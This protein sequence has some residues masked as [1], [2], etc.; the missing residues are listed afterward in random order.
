MTFRIVAALLAA[1]GVV[2]CAGRA[3][4]RTPAR[5]TLVVGQFGEFRALNPLYLMGYYQLEIDALMYTRLVWLDG[6]GKL[7]PQLATA[8]PSRENGGISRDGLTITYHLRHDAHWSDGVPLTSRDVA[9]THQ[10]QM[11]PKNVAPEE[12][13]DSEIR[14][15]E[16]P[17][18][19]TVRVHLKRPW[20]PFISE[21]TRGILPAHILGTDAS[22]FNAAF[23]AHPVG[24]GPYRFVEWLRGDHVTFEADP[25][26][27][28]RKPRI[29]RIQF[30]IIPDANTAAIELRSGDIQMEVNFDPA[31]L[32]EVRSDPKLR[33]AATRERA[34]R[35]MVFNDTAAPLTDVRLRKAL[36]LAID[37]PTI[38]RKATYGVD[39]PARGNL[40]VFGWAYDPAIA[41]L[42]YDPQEARRLLDA[43]GWRPGP[44]GIR[45]K[46]GQRLELSLAIV[47]GEPTYATMATQIIQQAKA[48]GVAIDIKDYTESQMFMTTQA[49]TL[50]GGHFQVAL[51]NFRTDYDPDPTWLLGC[52]HGVALPYNYEHYCDARTSALLDAAVATFDPPTRRRDY[53]LLQQRMN[54]EVPVV[55]FSQLVQLTVVPR[56]VENIDPIPVAGPFWNV[57]AWRFH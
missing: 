27:W 5:T 46:G 22:L 44:D 25:Q 20:A 16:T 56:A 42:P 52:D 57:T 38:V 15:L 39:D 43:A 19:Y 31:R 24:S 32:P 49:G 4:D 29:K 13:G 35:I 12:I 8:V 41:P 45:R 53:A 50:Y 40:A 7:V 26:Y 17:D 3:A 23:N 34:F 11:N 2:S 18:P 54:D 9:F 1:V 47:S 30:D 21:F 37:R 48:V 33:I 6:D 36:A 51:T 55:I 14:S 10:A 28:G